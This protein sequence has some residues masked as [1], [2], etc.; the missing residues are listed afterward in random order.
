MTE[1]IG[2]RLG[3]VRNAGRMALTTYLAQRILGL[4]LLGW[5]LTDIDLTRT[6]IAV[7]IL[8]V[9]ALELWWSTAWLQR[10]R[11]GPFEWAWRSATYRSRQQL[12]RPRTAR[13]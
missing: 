13:T 12:P 9:W 1:G 3:G 2:P 6:M 5:L 7:W 4:T 11:Y 10:S 8:G